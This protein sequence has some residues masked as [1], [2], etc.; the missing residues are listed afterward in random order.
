[1]KSSA[2]ELGLSCLIVLLSCLRLENISMWLPV[3]FLKVSGQKSSETVRFNSL[4]GT[5]DIT[6]TG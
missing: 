3:M 5:V 2:S 6:W 1:M 4:F